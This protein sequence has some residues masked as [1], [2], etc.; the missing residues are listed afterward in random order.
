MSNQEQFE[1][2]VSD[3]RVTIVKDDGIHR[4][5]RCGRV[6]TLVESFEIITWPGYLA[7]VGDMG[8]YVFRRLP[9][10]FEFFRGK[11]SINLAYW[12]EKVIAVDK[13]SGIKKHNAEKA[14]S[15]VLEKLDVIGEASEDEREDI[16]SFDF[17]NEHKLRVQLDSYSDIFTDIDE[18]D[19][20]EYTYHYEWCCRAIVWAINKYDSNFIERN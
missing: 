18:V 6:G 10:M 17:E 14:R 16:L 5:L 20:G 11:P 2:S 9:D 3:H 4:H 12:A 1:K 7:I 15:Y 19:W 13:H 8:D